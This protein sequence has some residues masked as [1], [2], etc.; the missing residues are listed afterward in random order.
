MGSYVQ[1]VDSHKYIAYKYV[2]RGETAVIISRQ[3]ER[4]GDNP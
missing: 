3:N 4:D 1:T 2:N